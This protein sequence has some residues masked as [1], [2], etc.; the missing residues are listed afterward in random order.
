MIVQVVDFSDPFH[1]E[2]IETTNKVLKDLGVDSIPM[3]YLLNKFD[4][5]Y[6]NPSFLPKENELFTSLANDEDLDDILKFICSSIAKNWECRKVVFP[7][8]KDFASFLRENY[9]SSYKEKEDGY[10]CTVFFNPL[11]L[12][13][14]RYLFE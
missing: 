7:Y 4:L 5:L 9:V 13:K 8:E 14:Y 11:T 6:K 3:V 10:E 12:Y 1:Q 2:Q